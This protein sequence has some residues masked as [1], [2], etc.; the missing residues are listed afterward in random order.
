MS[1]SQRFE[2]SLKHECSDASAE[3]P[4][5]VDYGHSALASAMGGKRTLQPFSNYDL[6]VRFKAQGVVA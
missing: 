2:M 1:K 5:W 6:E 3:C 4:Q